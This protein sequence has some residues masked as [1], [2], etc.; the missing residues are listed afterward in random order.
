TNDKNNFSKDHDPEGQNYDDSAIFNQGLMSKSAEVW[1][2]YIFVLAH[3]SILIHDILVLV[4]NDVPI[5][6]ILPNSHKTLLFRSDYK[7]AAFVAEQPELLKIA[8]QIAHYDDYKIAANAAFR[9]YRDALR[10]GLRKIAE[11]F[12]N[13]FKVGYSSQIEK[14]DVKTYLQKETWQ[15]FL[16]HFYEVIDKE[17]TLTTKFK[18]TWYTFML[19]CLMRIIKE[20]LDEEK[21]LVRIT[22]LDRLTMNYD[23]YDFGGILNLNDVDFKAFLNKDLDNKGKENKN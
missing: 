17:A 21:K 11:Y 9:F 22:D 12:I 3:E 16:N 23:L 15:S 20:M 5:H 7:A 8:N 13:D 19:K 14:V 6:D 4:Y 1:S 18:R 10:S 2:F